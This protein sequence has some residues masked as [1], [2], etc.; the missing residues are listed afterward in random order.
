MYARQG[1]CSLS[2]IPRPSHSTFPSASLSSERA[3]PGQLKWSHTYLWRQ[4][5]YSIAVCLCSEYGWQMSLGLVLGPF[6]KSQEL[7]YLGVCEENRCLGS[8]TFSL[9]QPVLIESGNLPGPLC[10]SHRHTVGTSSCSMGLAVWKDSVPLPFL[11]QTL[12]YNT[13][14]LDSTLPNPPRGC[15][16]QV[17]L[18]LR[19]ASFPG[20][21]E[22]LKQGTLNGQWVCTTPSG[23][24][25]SGSSRCL[26]GDCCPGH[27]GC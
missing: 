9:F 7:E 22:P 15:N 6:D 5:N 25:T 12:P 4:A 11:S 24:V 10:S 26:T 19:T 16:I 3:F 8:P 27:P 20:R 1:L 18:L 14:E 13:G 23:A 21:Q 17:I 2:S